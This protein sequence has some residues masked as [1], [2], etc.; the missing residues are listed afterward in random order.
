MSLPEFFP[1]LLPQVSVLGKNGLQ[2]KGKMEHLH[3]VK[4]PPQ[5][6][7]PLPTPDPYTL[8]GQLS[9]GLS[10]EA[11]LGLPAEGRLTRAVLRPIALYRLLEN[12]R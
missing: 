7:L 6:V 11:S 12:S 2:L 8:C 5:P 9:V 3:P 4:C 10:E 1:W